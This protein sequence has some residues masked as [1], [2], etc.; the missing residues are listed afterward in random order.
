MKIPTDSVE[1]ML[2][3]QQVGDQ[4]MQHVQG[5]LSD[6]YKTLRMY[7]EQGSA[8]GQGVVHYNNVYPHLDL[9]ASILYAQDTT[10]FA[11]VPAATENEDVFDRIPAA[12]RR[13]MDEWH[14]CNLDIVFGMVLIE[15]LIFESGFLKLMWNRGVQAHPIAPWS[16]GV[17]REDV[18]FLDRQEAICHEYT[19][20]EKA[21]YT[22]LENHPKREDL[23]KRIV[24][25]KSNDDEER[26]GLERI[27]VAATTPNLV[28][29]AVVP[30]TDLE[31][32]LPESDEPTALMRELYV[33]DTDAGDYRVVTM[34]HPGVTV[35]ERPMEKMFLK[36]EHPIVQICPNPK[37]GKLRGTSEVSR[38]MRL[39]DQL[40]ERLAD[41]QSLL[42]RQARPPT[43]ATGLMGDDSEIMLAMQTPGSYIRSEQGMSV[44]Q[45]APELPAD[46][47]KDVEFLFQ[48][49]QEMS[50]ITD[51]LQG[52]S[53][54]GVRSEGQLQGM[55]RLGS[56]RPKKR[57][58]V[59][60]DALD[61]VAEL[62]FKM[63]RKYSADQMHDVN[64]KPF[65]MA[66][67]P[68]DCHAKVDGHSSSPL[69]MQETKELAFALHK[70][71][72]IDGEDL[73][74]LT[75]PPN[76]DMLKTKLRKRLKAQAEAAAK[77]QAFE[78]AHPN[79]AEM[80][81]HRK[82]GGRA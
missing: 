67:V 54:Q 22:M 5:K 9:L 20:S 47:Y 62:T 10:R 71:Q 30:W 64:G 33:W 42:R 15:A 16:L 46:L 3:Y 6:Y 44:E 58:M 60:E 56:A 61:K 18:P 72:T 29:N 74:D 59:I 78:L 19:I 31:A 34:A 69:F 7:Y 79:V 8:D 51:I 65:I 77:Q 11:L 55:A 70:T 24:A 4:C 73:I 25:T 28:G 66:Q 17:L 21:L 26:S 39:Q 50:G 36:G 12:T 57:A 27:L 76:A 40:N 37:A 32:P 14:D 81:H 45:L 68:D 48:R 2:F 1:R 63:L 38:L 82:P 80:M 52:R 43:A 13:L 35:Y 75:Q 49:F 23:I 41:I 53:S